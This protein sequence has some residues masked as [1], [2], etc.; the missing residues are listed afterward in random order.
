MN[1][2]D[3]SSKRVDSRESEEKTRMP[4]NIK[5]KLLQQHFQHIYVTIGYWNS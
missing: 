1:L 5:Q 4:L 3:V 2:Y